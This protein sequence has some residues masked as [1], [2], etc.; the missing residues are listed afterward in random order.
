M[1]NDIDKDKI[2]MNKN[3]KAKPYASLETTTEDDINMLKNSILTLISNAKKSNELYQE[4]TKQL[5]EVAVIAEHHAQ[6]IIN[7]NQKVKMLM[8]YL[9][10]DYNDVVAKYDVSKDKIDIKDL[11]RDKE[12]V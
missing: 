4:T 6:F 3:R 9:D 10:I 11:P 8:Q 1:N 5:S 2:K 12:N 7:T